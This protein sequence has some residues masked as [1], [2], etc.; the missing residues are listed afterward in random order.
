MA[1]TFV[2]ARFRYKNMDSWGYW[3]TFMDILFYKARTTCT[4]AD[5]K[6]DTSKYPLINA[7]AKGCLQAVSCRL[8]CISARSTAVTIWSKIVCFIFKRRTF[9]GRTNIC[10]FG[11]SWWQ[12]AHRSP[13]S[14]PRVEKK[15]TQGLQDLCPWTHFSFWWFWSIGP[16]ISRT[17]VE[18]PQEN[19]G[20]V[21][22]P[23][24]VETKKCC[25]LPWV[26]S[27]GFSMFQLIKSLVELHSWVQSSILR[28]KHRKFGMLWVL[29][30]VIILMK[31]AMSRAGGFNLWKAKLKPSDP[32]II[33]WL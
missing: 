21:P 4:S 24:K 27:N 23:P 1:W 6:Y 17:G 26:V 9:L 29:C 3:G 12:K 30:A 22:E 33:S 8:L 11:T 32:G 18:V 31:S 5:E 2:L 19:D 14:Q 15:N 16:H 28:P 20:T 25:E 7:R 10:S 13:L